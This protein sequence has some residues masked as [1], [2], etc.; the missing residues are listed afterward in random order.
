MEVSRIKISKILSG[1]CYNFKFFQSFFRMQ[2]KRML[3]IAIKIERR[4]HFEKNDQR[5]MDLTGD[6]AKLRAPACDMSGGTEN[7]EGNRSLR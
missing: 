1:K 3:A 7:V 2:V 5:P 6:T 4:S